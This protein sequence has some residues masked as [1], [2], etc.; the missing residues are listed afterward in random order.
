MRRHCVVRALQPDG[1]RLEIDLAVQGYFR[2]CV[3]Y[4]GLDAAG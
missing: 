1:I 2:G 4:S 3:N